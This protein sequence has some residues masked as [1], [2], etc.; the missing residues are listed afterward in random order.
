VGE[1]NPEAL[2]PYFQT[3]RKVGEITNPYAREH[4]ETIYLGTGPSPA[5]M[6]RAVAER[7]QELAAWEGGLGR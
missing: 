3:L 7:R 2:K 6:A 1:G 5:L 4:G